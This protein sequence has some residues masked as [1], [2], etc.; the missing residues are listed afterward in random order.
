[1]KKVKTA[2][3]TL[4]L[5]V[6]VFGAILAIFRYQ[7]IKNLKKIESQV[8]SIS[9]LRKISSKLLRKWTNGA[10]DEEWKSI[11]NYCPEL[12]IKSNVDSTYSRCNATFFNC[13]LKKNKNTFKEYENEKLYKVISRKTSLEKYIPHFSIRTSIS[14][15]GEVYNI[16]LEDSCRDTYLPKQI[17]GYKNLVKNKKKSRSR[18]FS[19][20]WDNKNQ[21]IFIDKFLVT[22]REVN[23]WIST[24]GK[25]L[26]KRYPL[27][28]V[29]VNLSKD[30]MEE[31][32]RFKGKQLAS[33]KV[34]EAAT[35]YP[36]A[37]SYIAGGVLLRNDYPWTRRKK[38]SFLYSL[39]K[40]KDIK[41]TKEDCSRS[42]VRDCF[43][44]TPFVNHKTSSSTWVGI[45]Q[46]LGSEFEVFTNS[47]EKNRN[48]RAS[49]FYF[50]GESDVHRVGEKIYWDGVAHLDKNID[51]YN[52]KPSGVNGRSLEIGFRCMKYVQN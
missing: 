6:A 43:D 34:L 18:K 44:I 35:F 50:D 41:I 15:S 25:D 39:K 45:F 14:L 23:E 36:T 29:S 7:N 12:K 9:E 20:T 1:M 28:R 8:E 22:N 13:Y 47:I 33:A 3:F 42:Y 10:S 5:V 48:M 40:K 49:S 11:N 30:K 32:C 24:T 16:D 4:L 38:E 46:T 31:Y 51:W 52:N 27:E 19:W 17:Y 37:G 26:E 2:L 21:D